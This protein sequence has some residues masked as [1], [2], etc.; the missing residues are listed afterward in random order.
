MTVKFVAEYTKRHGDIPNQFAA[1]AYDA[2]YAVYYAATAAGITG[3]MEPE[4]VCELMIEQMQ[5]LE[6]TGLTSAGKAMVWDAT[7]AVAKTPTAAKI[8]NGV[9]VSL[10]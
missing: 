6:L 7:G 1:D 8:E 9:Y 3:D 10:D 2:V 4:E 5:K